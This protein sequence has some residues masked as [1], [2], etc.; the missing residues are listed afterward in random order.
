LVHHS[1]D[2][3]FIVDNKFKLLDISTIEKYDTQKMYKIY[4]IW[5]KIA[6]DSF[7]FNHQ[8][9]DFD[10][11]NHIVFAGMGGS[12]AIGD[13]FA[14]ILSKT[15]IHVSVVKGY[16][17]PKTVSKKT[18]I[19]TTSISGN[20]IETLTILDEANQKGCK[21]IAFTSGGKMEEYCKK[22]KVEYKKIKRIH[23]PRASFTI[24]LY[25]MLKV[26]KPI[27]PISMD[28][29]NDSLVQLE[30]MEKIINS[31]NLTES[32]PAL[33]LANWIQG[34]PIIYYPSGL[35]A[36]AIRFKN[37]LQENSKTHA[38]IE[39]IIESCHNGIVSWEGKSNFQPILLQG[40]EDYIKTKE[41]WKIFKR[42]FENKNI[43]YWENKATQGNI[44]SKIITMIYLY[45]YC[46]IYL[47][48]KNNIDPSP[49]KSIDFIKNEIKK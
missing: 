31:K 43:K 5:P 42:Y 34:V 30:V 44:L 39:D 25:S 26:L 3:Y 22:N 35:L 8:E 45:D 27:L 9:A 16:T 19:V 4:D 46:S 33:N 23:S 47:A 36:V 11:I 17:L 13:I 49:V 1:I 7:E 48:I 29:I 6:K 14:S 40:D 24:F 2:R 12:G 21:T 38:A 18:L 32:N 37:S 20:T 10:N 28:E 41:R 15:D